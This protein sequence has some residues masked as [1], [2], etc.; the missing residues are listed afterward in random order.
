MNPIEDRLEA[1]R[2][3]LAAALPTRT[4]T[5]RWV[6]LNLLAD[7]Q[8]VAGHLTLCSQG[9]QGYK[10]I[11]GRE[12]MDGV[13]SLALIGR[14]KLAEN[15]DALEVEKAELALV[16]DVKTWLRSLVPGPLCCLLMTGFQQSGQVQA[17]YGWVTFELEFLCD[18]EAG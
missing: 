17:P 1:I 13:H 16:Q 11:N 12:A 5:R 15:Q 10:N 8:L 14:L 9:E 18:G 3:S 7:D 6:A 2:V 4:V